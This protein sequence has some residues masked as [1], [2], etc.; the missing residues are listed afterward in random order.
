MFCI[1]VHAIYEFFKTRFGLG[2][3]GVGGGLGSDAMERVLGEHMVL[4]DN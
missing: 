2:W 4:K 3:F 1:S